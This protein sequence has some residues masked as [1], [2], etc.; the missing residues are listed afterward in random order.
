MAFYSQKQSTDLNNKGIQIHHT[1][2]AP[3]KAATSFASCNKLH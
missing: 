3:Y 2:A 1:C